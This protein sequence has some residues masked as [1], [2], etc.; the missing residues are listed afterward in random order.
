M[1]I[2]FEQVEK[3]REKVNVSFEDAKAAL[4]LTD[5]D[6]LDAVIYLEKSGKIDTPRMSAYNT[7]VGG[8]SEDYDEP[9]HPYGPYWKKKR[10]KAERDNGES[11][12]G[13]TFRDHMR[14]AWNKF[15]ELVRK[16]N[17]NYFVVS[18]ADEIFLR[19]PV[20]VLVLAMM[21]FFWITFPLLIIGLF[22]G[23][24]YQFRGPDFQKDTI[25]NVMDHAASTAES[26]KRSVMSE[27]EAACAAKAGT[28]TEQA[29]QER[30]GAD[31]EA[32]DED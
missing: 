24:R 5:G 20:T 17:A 12:K 16:G 22:C 28:K 7:R 8:I 4:E 13:P 31:S 3:L 25:N 30:S 18:K 2:T 21:F 10:W 14:K 9:G 23:H 6:L 1:T 27:A 11:Y 32:D 29:D 26:I 19:V 15:R